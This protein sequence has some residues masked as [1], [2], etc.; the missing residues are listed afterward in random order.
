MTFDLCRKIAKFLS[1][2]DKLFLYLT[3][4]QFKKD[5]SDECFQLRVHFE[6]LMIFTK[7]HEHPANS[8]DLKHFRELSTQPYLFSYPEFFFESIKKLN[9]QNENGEHL[10][11]SL[12]K[13]GKLYLLNWASKRMDFSEIYVDIVKAIGQ[14]DKHSIIRTKF[15]RSIRSNLSG[16]ILSYSNIC[17]SLNNNWIVNDEIK[18]ET[19]INVIDN[20]IKN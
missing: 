7:L 9:I 19:L 20:I 18:K 5:L 17:F 6:N 13:S 12:A 4:T 3:C 2:K 14:N 1:I 11:I 8:N 16:N 10:L 15:L